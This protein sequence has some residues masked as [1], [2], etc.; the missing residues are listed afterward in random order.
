MATPLLRS[1][2]FSSDVGSIMPHGSKPNL[3]SAF[4]IFSLQMNSRCDAAGTKGHSFPGKLPL[5]HDAY[6][7]VRAVQ[8]HQRHPQTFSTSTAT[9]AV[10][11]IFDRS[12]AIA[13]SWSFSLMWQCVKT[14]VPS[15]P[16]N[17]W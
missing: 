3:A 7:D 17:S 9:P 4:C 14:L 13:K 1:H 12:I 11:M 5:Q 16:Q 8:R 15:E 6:H 10:A 2:H